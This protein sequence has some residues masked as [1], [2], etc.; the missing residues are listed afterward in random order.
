MKSK[1]NRRRFIKNAVIAATAASAARYLAFPSILS[2]REPGDLLNYVAI[3]CGGR[4]ETHLEEFVVNQKQ[5]LV[6]MVDPDDKQIAGKRRWLKDKHGIDTDNVQFFSDYRVM[7]DK[8]GNQFDTV[9]VAA[10]NHHHATAAMMAMEAGKNVYCEKPL[11]H[12]IAEA[13]ALREA[14]LRYNK[15]ATQMGNQG[16]CKGGY[17]RLCEFIWGGVIGNVTETHSWT[18][19]ANG[20]VGPRPPSIPVPA[21]MHWDDW[22]G[23]APYRDFHSDLHPHEW[24]GWYDF[25][26]GSIGNMGCHVLE[27]V[28]WALKGDHPTSVEME[29]VRGGS[30]ER[31]PLGSRVRWDLPARGDMPPMKAYWYEGLNAT[32]TDQPQGGTHAAK[33]SARNLPPIIAKLQ[34]QYPDEELTRGD[35]GSLY[36]G[37]K[38]VIFTGTYGEKMH[39]LP[40][41]KMNEI[42]QPP[43]SL[44]R[45]NPNP[46]V[47]FVQTCRAGRTNTATPFEYGARLTEFCLLGNLAQ[48]A[49]KGNLVQWDSAN[50]KVTNIA[51]LNQWI[52]REDRKGWTTQG[53]A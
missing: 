49:G 42:K 22:I 15:V 14:S 32:T 47:D 24:H 26:N 3:G 12:D 17:H 43:M 16:H 46:F 37:D 36:I 30:D 35:S 18:D 9:S 1:M 20:G 10:P 11:T 8:L 33:G 19:R 31:Y 41:E 29:Y 13:R 53:L 28:F 2:A 39:V 27:G 25:G 5:H 52:K 50:M 38:G 44:P 6:A 4:G 21:G 40:L 7:F 48:H 23:P 34:E 45:P 51:E